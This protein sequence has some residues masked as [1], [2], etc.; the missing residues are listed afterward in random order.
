MS[1]EA[2]QA[3]GVAVNV[4]DRRN[5][6]VYLTQNVD[7]SPDDIK[8]FVAKAAEYIAHGS[9]MIEVIQNA[10]NTITQTKDE[11]NKMQGAVTALLDL[12]CDT[13][14]AE[15]L[16]EFAVLGAQIVAKEEAKASMPGD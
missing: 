12:S 10:Q 6:F 4:N 14:T 13:I 8:K 16:R 7:K 5:A 11:I 3:K 1:D 15:K 2:V 9:S